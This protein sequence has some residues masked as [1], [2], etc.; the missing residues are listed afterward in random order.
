MTMRPPRRLALCMLAA[1]L[2]G[3]APRALAGEA[4]DRHQVWHGCLQRS[5]TL[6]AALSSRSLAADS[7]LRACRDEEAAYLS[8]LSG[9][10]LLDAD[11]ISR[12]R[13]ALILRARGWLLRRNGARSL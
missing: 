4:A 12:V 9:S 5:F 3:P 6:Q 13:P 11:D 2:L 7:A 8:A 1:A 10:P